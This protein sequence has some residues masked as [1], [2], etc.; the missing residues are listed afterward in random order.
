MSATPLPHKSA[1][2]AVGATPSPALR[3]FEAAWRGRAPDLLSAVRTPAMQRFLA[4]GLPTTRDESWRYTNLRTLAA[5]HFVA[6]PALDLG[7]ESAADV[8][9]LS[10]GDGATVIT[11]GNGR[12]R[13]P[14]GGAPLDPAI[15]AVP[16]RDL[17][18]GDAAQLARSWP[19]PSDAEAQ[20]WAL[21]NTALFTDGLHLR[22]R[23]V[24]TTPLVLVHVGG[25]SGPDDVTFPS[26]IIEADAGASA[27]IVEHHVT[28]GRPL[29][30]DSATRIR[31]GPGAKLDHYRVF[32]TD[33]GA[34]NIDS[35]L[36]RQERDSHCREF[37][38]A[39]GGGLLRTN[40]DAELTAAGA[41]ID[42]YALLMGH[43]SRLVD[44]VNVARHMA[45]HTRS[46]QTARAIASGTSRVVFNTKVIVAAG[47]AHSESQQSCRGLLLSP[48]AEIDSRPQLEI[49]TDEVK[50]AHGA[51]TGRLDPDMFFYLL[52]RGLDRAS[53][54]SLLVFAFL[55]DVLT[56]MTLPAARTEIENRL[57][58]QLPDS[59]LLRSFR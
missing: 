31:L 38:I 15:S 47:A 50:C 57:I 43:E 56:G 14:A 30:A 32:T 21:L 24:A 4:L 17:A 8:A 28:A 59:A 2:A 55:A 29:F 7:A 33:A 10:A 41:A 22:I 3:A 1:T 6:A 5:K 27:T 25:G 13:L 39:L 54:Q 48:T 52:S 20:R 35:L 36:I 46:T 58:A 11:L 51:T 40:L 18:P 45:P 49:N 23:G 44:C 26:V 42:S 9:W 16:L 34:A 12:P 19:A 53:A 37:T